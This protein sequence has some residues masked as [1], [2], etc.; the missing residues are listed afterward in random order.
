MQQLAQDA[1]VGWEAYVHG[2]GSR[3]VRIAGV[4]G[5]LIDRL[6]MPLARTLGGH[7]TFYD[8]TIRPE[9]RSGGAVLEIDAALG[10]LTLHI[11][12]QDLAPQRVCR[13]VVDALNRSGLGWQPPMPARR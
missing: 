5:P 13:T 12:P 1:T 3:T 10:R 9:V 7:G 6:K 8:L 2:P 11:A 4:R